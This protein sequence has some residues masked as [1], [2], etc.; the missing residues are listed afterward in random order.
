MGNQKLI[1]GLRV[2]SLKQVKDERGAVFHVLK[3]SD[4]H[5]M[6]FGE[7][8]LSKIYHNVIKGWKCHKE[9]FQN[10]SVPYGEVKLVVFDG[11]EESSS[12]QLVNKFILSP[13]KNYKLISIPPNLWYGFQSLTGPFSLLLNISDMEHDPEES[14][15]LPLDYFQVHYDWES[16]VR[17]Q[18]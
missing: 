5:F 10:F 11:R 13:D 17:I 6:G 16:A 18:K 9:M 15:S 8:Y 1:E 12:Y 4:N 2:T 3:N 14:K 7:A